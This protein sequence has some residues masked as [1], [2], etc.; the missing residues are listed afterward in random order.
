M[1]EAPDGLILE[2]LRRLDM[3]VDRLIADV[4]DL[5][6]RM[7]A[8]RRTWRACSGGSIGSRSAWNESSGGSNCP[9][10]GTEEKE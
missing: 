7:K 6:I 9:M 3:K 5:K 4:H 10:R 8:S 2:I 1:V